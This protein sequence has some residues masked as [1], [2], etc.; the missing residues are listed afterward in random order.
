M[1]LPLLP[2]CLASAFASLTC[3][4]WVCAAVLIPMSGA[5]QAAAA[6]PARPNFIII[7]TD[8]QGIGDLGCYGA[9]DMKTPHLDRLAA[10][11]VRFTDWHSNATVCSPSRA[12]LLTGKYPQNAGIPSILY[13]KPGFDVAGL[14][15]GETTLPGELRKLGYRTAAV[16][17]WHLG[18]AAHSRPRA[19]GFDEWFGFYSGWIDYYSHRFYTLGGQPV[20]HDLWRNDEEVS[21]EP[22]YQTELLGREAREFVARQPKDR[23]FFLYLAFG[24]PHYPMM[25]PQKYL[26]RFPATMDR[27]RRL[28]CAMVAALDDE[29]GLL[30]AQ[31]QQLG[32]DEQTVIF[33]QSDNGATAEDRSDH[34]GRPYR[35]GSNHP[36]RGYKGSLW[37]GGLRMP[38]LMRW[39]GK[40]PAGQVVAELG[41]AMDIF[42]TFLR[43]AGGTVPAGIDGADVSGMVQRREKSPH[44]A[45][46]WDYE[47]RAA[48]REGPWK[49][50][51]GLCEALGD[52]V[53]P[54]TWLSN[55]HEDPA[56]T[57]NYAA[58]H[59]EMAAGLQAKLAA[60][61]RTWRP[62]P[63]PT[64]P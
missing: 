26:D 59:P 28:H 47:G 14:R 42:P 51:V 62:E 48:V 3:T 44:H 24:A 20:F 58:T 22:E 49:F 53:R 1:K 41:M 9:S 56:E 55:L 33:F 12:S 43:W 17:K 6:T 16:G 37:E 10:T 61:Q 50:Q 19:Q 8:D 54:E 5:A 23:P 25:A 46:Y 57:K 21:A 45:V 63:K 27:D 4:F 29:V 31:L 2:R 64:K 7:Y 52:V 38:A 34:R 35:G 13:S 11:G 18:S 36:Y 39:P 40:I 15:A 32:L 60:W 30:V